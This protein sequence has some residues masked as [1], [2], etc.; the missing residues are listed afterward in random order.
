MEL[1]SSA[2]PAVEGDR[3][4]PVSWTHTVAVT[5][6]I[7]STSTVRLCLP[8]LY[9]CYG[10][11]MGCHGTSRTPPTR[12]P[13]TGPKV[14]R[15]L[16]KPRVGFPSRAPEDFLKAGEGLTLAQRGKLKRHL[17]RYPVNRWVHCGARE[18]GRGEGN[19]TC[20][21]EVLRG[22]QGP[23]HPR[24]LNVSGM[25]V[26][27]YRQPLLR[28]VATSGQGSA[29]LQPL[30]SKGLTPQPHPSGPSTSES[31]PSAWKRR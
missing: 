21:Y 9:R 16:E 14:L 8:S 15:D 13:T 19:G 29:L 20:A 12:A 25:R 28:Q 26:V 18:T 3:K 6:V 30:A 7:C 27:G 31:N 11:H 4:Q 23:Q 17:Q 2:L 5:P 24:Y 10:S 22:I 1:H